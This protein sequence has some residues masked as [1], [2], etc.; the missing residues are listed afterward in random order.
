MQVS[1]SFLFISQLKN[2]CVLQRT[3]YS[4]YFHTEPKIKTVFWLRAIIIKMS[5]S[6]V[7]MKTMFPVSL[8]YSP[9]FST[10]SFCLFGD[11]TELPLCVL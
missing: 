4:D 10:I 3:L 2:N 7:L 9:S 5:V 1:S 8:S 6:H 11:E